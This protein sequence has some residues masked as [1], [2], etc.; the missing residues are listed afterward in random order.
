MAPYTLG[1]GLGW[2]RRHACIASA[3]A[4]HK[5]DQRAAHVPKTLIVLQTVY[6]K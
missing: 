5:R 3:D 1:H 4:H 2:R 6:I